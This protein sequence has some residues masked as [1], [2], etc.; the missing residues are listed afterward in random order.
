MIQIADNNLGEDFLK[1]VIEKT[2]LKKQNKIVEDYLF[3]QQKMQD[4]LKESYFRNAL[5]RMA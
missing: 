1:S 3:N 4:N 2:S 5:P